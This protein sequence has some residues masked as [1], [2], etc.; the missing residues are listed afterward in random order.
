MQKVLSAGGKP[1]EEVLS[2][3][4]KEYLIT[5]EEHVALLERVFHEMKSTEAGAALLRGWI[6][7]RGQA[8]GQYAGD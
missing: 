1:R 7:D 5:R 8:A 6:D 4:Q 2:Q 3:L